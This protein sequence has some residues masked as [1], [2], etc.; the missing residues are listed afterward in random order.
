MMNQKLVN[1]KVVNEMFNAWQLWILLHS[2]T[3]TDSVCGSCWL[4]GLY[5]RFKCQSLVAKDMYLKL[6]IE[7]AIKIDTM[8]QIIEVNIKYEFFFGKVCYKVEIF[9]STRYSWYKM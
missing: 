8:L 7:I 4:I 1:F 2:L 5:S 3:T 6:F 9:A